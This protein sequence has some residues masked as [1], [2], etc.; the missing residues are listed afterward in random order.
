M[1]VTFLLSLLVLLLF[2]QLYL[3]EDEQLIRRERELAIQQNINMWLHI[4]VSWPET[5][6]I[7]ETRYPLA[8]FGI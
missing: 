4:S 3:N 2:E 8:L 1:F 6:A 5:S 7:P